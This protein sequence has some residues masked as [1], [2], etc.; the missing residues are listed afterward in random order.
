MSVE[1]IERLRLKVKYLIFQFARLLIDGERSRI[2]LEVAIPRDKIVYENEKWITA[3]VYLGYSEI[4]ILEKIAE[5]AKDLFDKSW[6]QKE[7]DI[8]MTG[9][10]K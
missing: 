1:V 5:T 10:G 9:K 2:S 4:V 6:Q 8:D 3:R 7:I